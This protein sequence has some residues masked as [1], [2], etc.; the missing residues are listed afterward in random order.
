MNIKDLEVY[1]EDEQA[2][3]YELIKKMPVAST[4]VL[5]T[6]IELV[7]EKGTEAAFNEAFGNESSNG[8]RVQLFFSDTMN[9]MYWCM[10]YNAMLHIERN[11]E[12]ITS[13]NN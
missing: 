1:T 10:V 13:K 7:K 3:C 5:P 8:K 6:M 12:T 11:I 9:K 4:T 2:R